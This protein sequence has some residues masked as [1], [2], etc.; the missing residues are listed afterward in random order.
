MQVRLYMLRVH[1][2]PVP[3][4]SEGRAVTVHQEDHVPVVKIRVHCCVVG[5]ETVEGCRGRPEGGRAER[6]LASVEARPFV[7]APSSTLQVEDPL[8]GATA[9]TLTNVVAGSRAVQAHCSLGCVRWLHRCW[10]K[11]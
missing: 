8:A 4:A 11:A 9:I 1:Y 10:V 5:Q 2:I 3:V 7:R 6:R